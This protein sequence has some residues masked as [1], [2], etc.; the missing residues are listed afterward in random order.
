MWGVLFPGQGSQSVGMGQFLAENFKSAKLSYQEANDALSQNIQKLCFQGPESDLGL[1]ENTQPALLA[2]SIAT[3]RAMTEVMDVRVQAGAGHSVGEYA[4]VVASGALPFAQALRAVRARGRAMQ[5]AVPVGEGA[6]IAVLG[7]SDQQVD[8]MLAWAE[9]ERMPGRLEPANY[10]SPGQV[11]ISGDASAADWL[12]ANLTADAFAPDAP[13]YKLIPLNVSA[14]F[15]CRLMKPAEEEMGT[16]LGDIEFSD[17]RWNIVQNVNAEATRK[18]GVLRTNLVLQV[19][20][21]VRWTQ[22]IHRLQALG[23]SRFIECG[24]GKVLAGLSKKIDS[25]R[26]TTFNINTLDDFRAIEKALKGPT[27]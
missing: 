19:T 14:P 9:A 18:A 11:V 26:L 4:A 1:T 7:L 15:H 3:F 20:G 24:A 10:N 2:T 6:M 17:A 21:A 25:E 5:R 23:L 12:R 27:V 22:C 16:V 13:R 8:A